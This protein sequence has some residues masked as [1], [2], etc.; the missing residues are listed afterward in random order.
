M[1]CGGPPGERTPTCKPIGRQEF[2]RCSW[3]TEVNIIV[4]RIV[5]MLNKSTLRFVPYYICNAHDRHEHGAF[6]FAPSQDRHG[7]L[8]RVCVGHVIPEAEEHQGQREDHEDGV[9]GD[10]PVN[11][12]TQST[13]FTTPRGPGH[14]QRDTKH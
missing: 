11:H 8:R 7:P 14:E 3:K 5:S 10:V 2:P 1:N 6:S 4:M 12:V 9:S 13:E